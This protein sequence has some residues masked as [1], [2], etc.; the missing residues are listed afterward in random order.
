MS[1]GKSE[2]FFLKS[3]GFALAATLVYSVAF[4]PVGYAAD[5]RDKD[6]DAVTSDGN[7]TE[8]QE[9]GLIAACGLEQAPG[10]TPF[11]RDKSL[12]DSW[13]WEKEKDGKL[14]NFQFSTRRHAKKGVENPVCEQYVMAKLYSRSGKGAVV[15]RCQNVRDQIFLWNQDM[16]QGQ[17]GDSSPDTSLSAL[18][19]FWSSSSS[20]SSG[21]SARDEKCLGEDT[22]D[23]DKF[24]CAYLDYKDNLDSDSTKKAAV[25]QLIGYCVKLG[26]NMTPSKDAY[27]QYQ[28]MANSGMDIYGNGFCGGSGRG[29]AG[30]PIIVQQQESTLKTVTNGILGALKIGLPVAAMWDANRRENSNARLAIGYNHDLGFPSAVTSGQGGGVGYGYGG[31]GYGYGGGGYGYGGGGGYGYGGVP[32]GY[33]GMGGACPYGNCYGNGG[34]SLGGNIGFG[35]GACGVPPYVSTYTGCGGGVGIGG[36]FGGGMGGG[37]IPIGVGGG[38]FGGGGIPIGVGGGGYNPYAMGG[39]GIPIGVGGGGGYN[40]YA[41]GNGGGGYNPYAIGNGGGGYNPY[42]MGNG[43][44]GYNPYAGG[45]AGLPGPYG[46]ANGGNGWPNGSMGPN[47]YNGNGGNGYY[48]PGSNLGQGSWG[49]GSAPFNAA[50]VNA[51][52]QMY[53]AYAA[54]MARQA[55]QIKQAATEYQNTLSDMQQVQDRSYQAW[56]AYQMAQN[57]LGGSGT[58][59]SGGSVSGQQFGYAPTYSYSPGYSSVPVSGSGTNI[60]FGLNYNH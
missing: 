3:F 17:A 18:G 39:G 15:D 5:S 59:Y 43:G 41:M 7:P 47:G 2:K 49:G 14:K 48:G 10:G 22:A 27:K 60:S 20:G 53:Q 19:S 58:S 50:A 1:Y 42:G 34:I 40:P 32:M 54:Q 8:A 26:A 55:T 16:N 13:N 33:T 29:Y 24:A 12:K 21:E 9:A 23:A 36:G 52:A 37:G 51:Q 45:G 28:A 6:K 46:T 11:N 57:G 44:G 4:S 25:K 35:S 38:G 30:G 31:G 56:T